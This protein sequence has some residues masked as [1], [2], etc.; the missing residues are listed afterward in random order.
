MPKAK[1]TWGYP[2]TCEFQ[3]GAQA[4]IAEIKA[5]I[6]FAHFSPWL[7]RGEMPSGK[8]DTACGRVFAGKPK[9]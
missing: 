2:G 7:G 6:P 5:A 1:K 4:G 8:T 9:G 3:V